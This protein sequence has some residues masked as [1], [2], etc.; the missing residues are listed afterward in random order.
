M[1]WREGLDHLST[2]VFFPVR[3]SM[4]FVPVMLVSQLTQE[5]EDEAEPNLYCVVV[6]FSLQLSMN[7][8][9]S[10]GPGFSMLFLVLRKQRGPQSRG[11]HLHNWIPAK[12]G[13][14]R[15]GEP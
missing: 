11:L 8:K 14:G 4:E 12:R 13:R 7:T 5:E 10:D 3:M 9:P 2:A 1:I 6:L 15:L